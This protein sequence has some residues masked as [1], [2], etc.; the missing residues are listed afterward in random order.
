[1]KYA[2]PE[3]GDKAHPLVARAV[4]VFR[5]A[6]KKVKERLP[7]LWV[8]L[9]PKG[10]QPYKMSKADSTYGPPPPHFQNQ[11]CG[12]CNLAY[13][14]EVSG[15]LICAWVRGTINPGLWCRFWIP[16]APYTPDRFAQ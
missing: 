3:A 7:L 13:R 6:P 8:L 12:N 5:K 10:T 4:R 1:M 15:V 9:G 2:Y 14:H 11:R 16:P